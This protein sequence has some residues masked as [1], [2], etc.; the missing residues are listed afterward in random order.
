MRGLTA[1]T[2]VT[3]APD[4]RSSSINAQ[5][6]LAVSGVYFQNAFVAYPVCSASKAAMLTG[7]CSHVNGLQNNTQNY[8]KPAS[9]LT[10]AEVSNPTPSSVTCSSR[11][12]AEVSRRT[13][14]SDAFACRTALLSPGPV[15]ASGLTPPA[16]SAHCRTLTL[17]SNCDV[18]VP[19]LVLVL[20][21]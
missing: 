20:A 2:C 9:Q 7:R 15:Y 19:S 17:A 21:S 13:R 18:A 4:L 5:H 10:P 1:L 3:S 16:L 6:A 11:P 14:T 12:V 8:H